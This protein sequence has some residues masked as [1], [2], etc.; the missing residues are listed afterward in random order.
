MAGPP[1][2][3]PSGATP[4]GPRDFAGV[5]RAR[6]MV[7][8]Y[9]PDPVDPAALDRILDTARRGPSAGFSQ[10]QRFVVVTGERSRRAIADACGEPAAVARGLA[11][12]LSVAPVHVLPCVRHASYDERYGQADKAASGGPGSW[13]VPFGWMDGGAALMLLLLAVVEEGLGAGF[14]AIDPARVAAAVQIPDGWAPMGL[15]TI[16]HAV[17]DGRPGSQNRPRLP[18]S[19]IVH[20]IAD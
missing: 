5:V 7:R 1:P 20:R 4:T 18:L 3:A 13:D 2:G 10:P 11:P 8:R 16:G 12:W 15:V 19:E 9:R 17:D 6:R 14:L